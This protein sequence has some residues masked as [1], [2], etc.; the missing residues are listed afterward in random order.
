LREGRGDA[1]PVAVHVRA[2]RL[3][4]PL[5]TPPQ[6]A[7]SERILA[8]LGKVTAYYNFKPLGANP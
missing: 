8:E 5:G 6:P 7:E 4:S 2:M 3:F 1:A